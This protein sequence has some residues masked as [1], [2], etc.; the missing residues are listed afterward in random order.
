MVDEVVRVDLGEL[1]RCMSMLN[2]KIKLL[3][4]PPLHSRQR[5]FFHEIF[6][7]W[8]ECFPAGIFADRCHTVI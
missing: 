8:G 6:V 7:E 4:R 2:V 5:D 1:S 3:P